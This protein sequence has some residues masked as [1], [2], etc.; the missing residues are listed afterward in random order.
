MKMLFYI[1]MV[2]G[3]MLSEQIIPVD[4]SYLK[5]K[6]PKFDSTLI[7]IHLKL[8]EGYVAQVNFI[9]SHLDKTEDPFMLQS[10]RKQYGFEYDGMRLH[11]LYF[12]QLGGNGKTSNKKRLSDRIETTFG[13]FENFKSKVLSFAKTRGIGWVIL[14]GKIDGGDLKLSWVGDHEKGFL[15]GFVPVCVIDLWE[16]AY[17]SQFGLD[18]TK[19]IE[20]LFEYMDWSVINS[21]YIEN[22]KTIKNN[23]KEI[24]RK[25]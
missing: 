16:H 7:D 24:K 1:T 10:L 18:K 5:A 9:E 3:T 4:F 13:S 15:S 20:L 22:C 19:Y 12:S 23:Y 17:L 21:R 6:M 2:F 25:F 11:E 14:F 8:Y